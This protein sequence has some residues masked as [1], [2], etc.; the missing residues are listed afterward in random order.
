MA[1]MLQLEILA[2]RDPASVRQFVLDGKRAG[3]ARYAN[4]ARIE[5]RSRLW[6]IC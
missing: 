5:A 1:D 6:P 3:K 2:L 4:R